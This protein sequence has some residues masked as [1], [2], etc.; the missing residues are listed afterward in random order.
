MRTP[1]DMRAP[2]FPV[3]VKGVVVIDD[4]VVVLK[5]ERDEWELPGGKLDP[6]EQPVECIVREI[7]EELGIQV[8]VEAILD[9]WVYRIVP[10]VEVLVVTYGCIQAD[11]RRPR[12]SNEHKELG[13]F[14][15]D[16]VKRLPM[17][18]G[19][20]TSIET[21]ARLLEVKASRT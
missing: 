5:N 16:A 7:E 21:W 17:P 19:Y 3:S 13:L 20:K 11:R 2:R 14:S 9:S 4:H 15:L 10:G 18:D 8:V 1:N 12:H 6:E